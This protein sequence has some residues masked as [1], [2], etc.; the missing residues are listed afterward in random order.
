MHPTICDRFQDFQTKYIL[1]YGGI[2]SIS[3][4]E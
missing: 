3:A 1:R 2:L 4:N